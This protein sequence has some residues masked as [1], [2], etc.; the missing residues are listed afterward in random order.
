MN[1]TIIL[2]IA[3]IAASLYA[4][5]KK[6]L[7]YKWMLNPYKVKRNNQY[8]RFITSGFIHGDYMH[9]GFNMIALYSFGNN[10][11]SELYKLT[12]NAY[13]LYFFGVYLLALIVSDL[14]T[15]FKYQNKPNYNSLGASGAVSAI[16]FACILLD[17]LGKVYIYFIPIPG[18]IFGVLYLI[19]SY[20]SGKKLEGGVNHDAHFYGAVFGIAAIIALHPKALIEFYDDVISYTLKF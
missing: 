3:N 15:Y 17:P 16:I 20:Y 13:P 12:G 6:D 19:Y 1:F 11:E 9:L 10:F 5:D 4:W 8:Y 7:Y 14:P 18:F 2:I